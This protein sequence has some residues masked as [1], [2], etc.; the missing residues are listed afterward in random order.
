MQVKG[1]GMKRS[2]LATLAGGV[3]NQ[4][5]PG[6]SLFGVSITHL[7][8]NEFRANSQ[9]HDPLGVNSDCRINVGRRGKPARDGG[10]TD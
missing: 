5:P 4:N 9:R 7:P 6:G 1:G 3:N 10:W 8:G 2:V